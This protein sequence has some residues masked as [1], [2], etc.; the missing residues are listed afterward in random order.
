MNAGTSSVRENSAI[1]VRVG[2][3]ELIHK[4]NFDSLRSLVRLLISTYR[5]IRAT[6]RDV[7][8][9]QTECGGNIFPISRR[10]FVTSFFL[11]WLASCAG[12]GTG[13]FVLNVK[14]AACYLSRRFYYFTVYL[15]ET[16]RCTV[17]SCNR[18][19]GEVN[20]LLYWIHLV[21]WSALINSCGYSFDHLHCTRLKS[22]KITRQERGRRN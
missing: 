12:V 9:F 21:G 6:R 1:T 15:A 16:T 18:L 7:T 20:W 19:F 13:N 14:F 10:F 17:A 4:F 3:N 11:R 2:N 22:E 8:Q 5:T